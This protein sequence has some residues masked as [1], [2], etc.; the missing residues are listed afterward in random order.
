MTSSLFPP[1]LLSVPCLPSQFVFHASW[2]V[3]FFF[4]DVS[5]TTSSCVFDLLDEPGPPWFE[6]ARFIAEFIP[7]PA[8][9]FLD[10]NIIGIC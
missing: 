1:P 7:P 3:F 9:V 6:F 8:F 5:K 4:S 2:R 10:L